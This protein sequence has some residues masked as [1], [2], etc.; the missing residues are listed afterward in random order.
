MIVPIARRRAGAIACLAI[1]AAVFAGCGGAGSSP[2]APSADPAKD[3]LAQV[4]TRGT[5]VLWT[6]PAY[7]PQSFTVGRRD[8]DRGHEVRP[9]PADR[10]GGVRLR[11]RDRQAGRGGARRR[12]VLRR[13]AASTR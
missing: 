6:D 11:R 13:N 2:G 9:E 10:P 3:K 4:L 7:P 5:L 8:A 12:A 1:I